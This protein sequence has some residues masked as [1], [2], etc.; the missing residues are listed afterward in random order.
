MLDT[1]LKFGSYRVDYFDQTGHNPLAFGFYVRGGIEA[2]SRY[3]REAKYQLYRG[4]GLI[5]S[6][7]GLDNLAAVYIDVNDIANLQRPAY[8]QLKRDLLDGLFK[9]V[10]ILESLA[11][12]GEPEADRDFYDFIVNIPGFELLSCDGAGSISLAEQ[13]PSLALVSM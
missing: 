12:L 13:L 2:Q 11:L 8:L 10:F 3:S 7:L 1:L 4:L 6:R 9:R 5:G